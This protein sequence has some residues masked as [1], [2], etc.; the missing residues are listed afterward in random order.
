M[1]VDIVPHLPGERVEVSMAEH[2]VRFGGDGWTL[3][4]MG[5]TVTPSD[6]APRLHLARELP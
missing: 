2:T 1:F 3:V 4:V 5:T 6:D